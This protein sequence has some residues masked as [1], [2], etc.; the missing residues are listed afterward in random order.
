MKKI[1]ILS[2]S[3]YNIYYKMKQR[4]NLLSGTYVHLDYKLVTFF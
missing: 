2:I 4:E 1:Y 3:V